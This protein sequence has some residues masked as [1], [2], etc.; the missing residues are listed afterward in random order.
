MGYR[1]RWHLSRRLYG[2]LS[3]HLC[4]LWRYRGLNGLWRWLW[5]GLLCYLCG[6]WRGLWR[7]LNEVG[8]GKIRSKGQRLKLIKRERPYLVIFFFDRDP[9]SS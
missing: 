8:K 6:L 7:H 1:L 9:Q 3:R 5:Y 4:G 2:R